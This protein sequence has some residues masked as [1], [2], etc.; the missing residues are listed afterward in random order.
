MKK[1]YENLSQIIAEDIRAISYSKRKI[2]QMAQIENPDIIK[3]FHD[4]GIALI[5]VCGHICNWEL[6]TKIDL[7]TNAEA[8]GYAGN[9][10]KFIYKRQRFRLS[11]TIIRWIRSMNTGSN[12]E[13][14]DSKGA[15]RAILKNGEKPG[16]YFMVA[17]QAPSSKSKFAVKFLNQDTLMINGPE[18]LSRSAGCPVVYAEMLRKCRGQ[19]IIRFHEITSD[20]ASCDPGYITSKYASL[21]ESSIRANPDTWLWSHRRW[22][23]GVNGL[24]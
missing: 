11:D 21:L 14:I 20:P 23:K 1:F 17:D 13:L 7:F 6:C 4:K 10:L 15:A 2:S 5:I 22:K 24:V 16:C 8:I 3:N 12:I 19:Y 9:E 18:F